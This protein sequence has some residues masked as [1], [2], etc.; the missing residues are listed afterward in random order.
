MN[1]KKFHRIING[2]NTKTVVASSIFFECRSTTLS[3]FHSSCAECQILFCCLSYK[4]KTFGA[5]FSF[6]P[7]ILIDPLMALGKRSCVI[8]HVNV[9]C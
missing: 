1:S 7:I 3:C 6:G 9:Y 8:R 2:N 4:T 5:N